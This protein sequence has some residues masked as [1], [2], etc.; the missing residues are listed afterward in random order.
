MTLTV[1]KLGTRTWQY[2]WTGTA[3]FDVYQDGEKIFD[4]TTLT[5]TILKSASDVEPP[6]LEVV[7]A[8]TTTIAESLTHSPR[9]TIQWRGDT[10]A[11][12]YLVQENVSSVWTT[13]T[14]LSESGRGYYQFT[15]GALAD[16]T[17]AQ[18]QVVIVD[19]VGNES[20]GLPFDV[21]PVRNPPAP[22]ITIS[23]DS[24]TG[25]VTVAAA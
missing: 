21:F 2:Q 3:P 16:V 18:W 5:E 1:K 10:G 25:N 6:V 14:V 12:F 11:R 9:S 17:T 15:T 19:Q 20:L 23:Y 8:D 24:G 13:R 7:D 4:Q 22:D